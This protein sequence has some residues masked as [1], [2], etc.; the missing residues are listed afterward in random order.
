MESSMPRLVQHL[1]FSAAA[2]LALI[3]MGVPATAA[4]A[5]FDEAHPI[6]AYYYGWWEPV[7]LTWGLRQPVEMPAPSARQIGDDRN[8]MQRHIAQ[9]RSAGIDGFVVNRLNDLAV[10][11]ELGYPS[12]F[13]ATYQLDGNGGIESQ[14]QSFYRYIDHPAMVRHQGRAV[15]FFW[16]ASARD[17]AFWSEMRA[18]FDPDRQV[19]WLADGDNFAFPAGDAWDGISPYAIAWSRDPASQLPAW[20]A[21]AR[22]QMPGKLYVPPVSPGCDDSG[23]RAATCVQP[24]RDGAYYQATLQ[25]ALASKPEWGVVVSTWNEWMEDTQIEP[26]IQEGDLY[27][28]LTRGFAQVFKGW[29]EPAMAELIPE[30]AA[31]EDQPAGAEGP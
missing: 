28:H 1:L 30:E 8:L 7:K 29:P 22:A 14:L 2:V 31:A 23:V 11:L 12:D 16:R 17:N 26:S 6:L 15:L 21:K 10:M 13:R 4:G 27:L 24:R 5:Q 19:V 3:P 18:R 20:G 25:G 9:A